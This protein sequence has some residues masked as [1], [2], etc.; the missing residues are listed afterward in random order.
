MFYKENPNKIFYIVGLMPDNSFICVSLKIVFLFTI[1]Y[2]AYT[3]AEIYRVDD[4]KELI[5]YAR[6]RGVRVV[7]EI[8]APAHAGNGWQWGKV[9]ENIFNNK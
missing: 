3:P 5:E 8:D 6:A 1:R 7:I 9:S 2:G 4:Q